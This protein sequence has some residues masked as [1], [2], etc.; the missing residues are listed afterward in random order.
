MLALLKAD[1]NVEA[2]VELQNILKLLAEQLTQN[3][4]K[5]SVEN[6]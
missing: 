2:E 1:K 5:A 3:W 4:E 6:R